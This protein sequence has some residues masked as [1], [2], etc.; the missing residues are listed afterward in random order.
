MGTEV[1][2]QTHILPDRKAVIVSRPL[3]VVRSKEKIP[4]MQLTPDH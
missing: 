2:E 4:L 1:V 3:S